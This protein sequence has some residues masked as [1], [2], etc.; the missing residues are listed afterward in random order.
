VH[1]P[2]TR[3]QRVIITIILSLLLLVLIIASVPTILVAPFLPTSGQK[4]VL[5]ILDRY[6]RCIMALAG[7]DGGSPP[8]GDRHGQADQDGSSSTSQAIGIPDGG[9]DQDPKANAATP[10]QQVSSP[11]RT[12]ILVALWIGVVTCVGVLVAA[13]LAHGALRVAG[14][15]FGAI[16]TGITALWLIRISLGGPGRST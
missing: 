10:V 9:G 2:S 5:S 8:E 16:A 14:I 7:P 6:I 13:A 12:G 11:D 15:L 3:W 4:T 1:T